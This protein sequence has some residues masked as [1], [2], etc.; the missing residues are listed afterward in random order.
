MSWKL[1]PQ[2]DIELIELQ[3]IV[4]TALMEGMG[5]STMTGTQ[6]VEKALGW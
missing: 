5:D 1:D 6:M 4:N 2:L 3:N